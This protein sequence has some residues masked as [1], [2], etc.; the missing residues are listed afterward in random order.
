MFSY[1]VIENCSN[2]IKIDDFDVDVIKDM[3]DYI[4]IRKTGDVIECPYS[5][6]AVADKYEIEG[7]QEASL[8]YLIFN[9]ELDNAV[10]LLMLADF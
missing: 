2:T 1:N 7:L 6:Y 4:N 5:L 9:L 8:Q 10:E 3:I